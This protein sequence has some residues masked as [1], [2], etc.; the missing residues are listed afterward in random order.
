MMYGELCQSISWEG[1]EVRIAI[2]LLEQMGVK[3]EDP[4][5]A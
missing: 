2:S 5:A 1:N 3:M 4:G